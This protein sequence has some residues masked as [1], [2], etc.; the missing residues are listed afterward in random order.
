M[1]LADYKL[2][3][4]A[5][6]SQ[7]P[8]RTPP[9]ILKSCSHHPTD[10]ATL[11]G[12]RECNRADIKLSCHSLLDPGRGKLSTPKPVL[13]GFV[14]S[15]HCSHG[16]ALRDAS[17]LPSRASVVMS[18]VCVPEAGGE[19]DDKDKHNDGIVH[20][21]ALGQHDPLRVS[22]YAG[23]KPEGKGNSVSKRELTFSLVTGSLTGRKNTTPMNKFHPT[24]T[25]FTTKLHPFAR[26]H[27][28]P[29]K[30]P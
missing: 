22:R 30:R 8:D 16:R 5:Y 4:H 26:R 9:S 19:H 6:F 24:A 13:N 25:T 23:R 14:T 3:S 1:S 18:S 28:P 11:R 7:F 21:L 27:G 12:I 15:S 10:P 2:N 20:L 17:R 29:S